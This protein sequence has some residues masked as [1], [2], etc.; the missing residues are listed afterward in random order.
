MNLP[1]TRSWLPA[2]ATSREAE[3]LA[4]IATRDSDDLRSRIDDLVARN[5]QIHNRDCINLNPATNVMNPRAEAVLSA[6]LGTRPSLGHPGAKYE[7]GLEAIEELEVITAALACRVFDAA[8]AEIRPYSGAMANLMTFMACADPGD[9]IIVPPASIGGHVTHNTA[10][11]AGLYGLNI[12][13]API[14]ADRYTVDVAGVAELAERVKPKLITVGASMNL[15]PHPVA[16]L[17]RIADEA[18]ARLM[19]DA[20]HLCAMFAG[21]AWANP[22]ADGA[23]VMTMS[24]YK[25]LAGPAGG[26]IVT[27]DA[28]LAER[29]DAIAYPGMTANFDAGRTTALG[30]T[31]LDWIDSG[32]DHVAAMVEAAAALASGL[33][34]R[35][36][37]LFNTVEGPTTSHQLALAMPDAQAAAAAVTRL[38]AANLLT[39]AIG[40]PSGSGVRVGTPEVVR[41]GMGPTEMRAVAGFIADAFDAPSDTDAAAT[42]APAVTALRAPFS[43]VSFCT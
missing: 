21:R 1:Q 36:V 25:S 10:G 41:W 31:L 6:G 7:V 15:V 17:R 35:G 18:G 30:I 24:T 14:D 29:I 4:T 26:L 9:A 8:Y 38:R 23:H 2:A 42:V 12:H 32:R 20:A 28:G 16:E 43:Q 40:L 37:A 5:E 22:L 11:A 33:A 39:C 27:D 13:E 19:F 34:E 3:I